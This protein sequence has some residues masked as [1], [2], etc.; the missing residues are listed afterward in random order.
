MIHLFYQVML[1]PWQ[2]HHDPSACTPSIAM[3]GGDGMDSTL[4]YILS[5][6]RGFLLLCPFLPGT[7]AMFILY[8]KPSGTLEWGLGSLPLVIES[9]GRG[10]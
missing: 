7:Q 4:E 10:R 2:S 1:I 6:E 5:N 3:S 9:S 8:G